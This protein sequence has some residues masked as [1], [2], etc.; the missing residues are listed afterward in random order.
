MQVEKKPPC[1]TEAPCRTAWSSVRGGLAGPL[2]RH[3]GTDRTGTP[4]GFHK[5]DA[6]GKEHFLSTHLESTGFAPAHIGHQ[7]GLNA[8][9][10]QSVPPPHGRATAAKAFSAN[11]A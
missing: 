8:V 6:L 2:E 10:V 7:V 1:D 3:L 11:L 9:G 4:L 5:G